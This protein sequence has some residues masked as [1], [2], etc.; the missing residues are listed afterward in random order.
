M[1]LLEL[2]ERI[3]RGENLHTEFKEADV[4]SDDIAAELVAFANT[5]GGQLIFGVTDDGR[6][7]GVDDPDRLVQR[8][9]QIAYQNC[10]PPITVI[11]ETLRDETGHTVLIVNVP[12]GDQ[13]PY[14]TKQRGD[15]FIRTS[16]GRRRA[17]RQELLRLFQAAE[18]LYYDETLLLQAALID[19]DVNLFERFVQHAYQR[20]VEESGGFET[21]LRKLRLGREHEGML[22]PTVAAMLFFGREPQRFLPQAHLVAARFPEDDLSAAPSDAKQIGGTLLDALEDAVRF[23]NIHLK[24]AHH[25]RSFEPEVFPELPLEA[26]RE[27]LVNALAH[28]DYTVAAPVRVFVF[29]NRVEIRTPGGLPNTVTIDAIQMGAAHVLRNPTV[30]TLFSRWGLVTGVGTGVYR[31]I[32]LIRRTTG[33]EPE[34][35]VVGN[36]FVVSVFRPLQ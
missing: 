7:V 15:F 28:R 21:L 3:R 30:Y 5:D 33:Q 36:E 20:S 35:S 2:L 22:Y 25:I 11:Q 10:E 34:L 16:S 23:L 6:I 14:Q 12:K 26:L 9:D 24:T 8:V 27:L 29:D 17:S 19:L 18:S 31:A 1:T 32:G 13:R 4:H